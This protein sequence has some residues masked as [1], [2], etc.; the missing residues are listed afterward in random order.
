[1]TEILAR[2]ADGKL[3]RAEM[4]IAGL[5]AERVYTSAFPLHEGK[6]T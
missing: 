5:P 2:T 6:I 4:G 1:M 3:K